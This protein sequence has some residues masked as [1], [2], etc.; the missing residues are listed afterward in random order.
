MQWSLDWTVG[1]ILAASAILSPILTALINNRH[2]MKVR[3]MEIEQEKYE[4]TVCYK[5]KLIESYL[6]KTTSCVQNHTPEHNEEYSESFGSLISYV[7]KD[8]QHQMI[9][10]DNHINAGNTD[11]AR[12]AFI[13]L[14]PVLTD[15]VQKL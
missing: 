14:I 3:K 1:S 11:E 10:I 9:Y 4:E 8:I 5:R 13:Q 12:S 7:P 15:I 6:Q 2:L